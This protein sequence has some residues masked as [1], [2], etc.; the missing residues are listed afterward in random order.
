MTETMNAD[1]KMVD[2]NIRRARERRHITQEKMAEM[3]GLSVTY[4]NRVENGKYDFTLERLCQI[5]ELLYTPVEALLVGVFEPPEDG[6]AAQKRQIVQSIS[7]YISRQPIAFA[8]MLL[9]VCGDLTQYEKAR[10]GGEDAR[11]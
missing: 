7:T 4:Y 3:L 10:R 6:E 2:R 9:N 1:F 8:E 5:S 11:C